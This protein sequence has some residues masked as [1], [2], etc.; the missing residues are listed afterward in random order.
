MNLPAKYHLR[1]IF[2]DLDGTL[3]DSAPDISSALELTFQALKIEPHSEQKVRQWVGNG[4]EKLLHRALTNSMDGTAEENIMNKARDVFFKEYKKNI[5]LYSKLYEGVEETLTKLSKQHFL[6]ACITNKNRA[7]TIPLLEK[8]KVKNYFNTIV[9]GDDVKHKKPAADHLL[10]GTRQLGVT[11]DQ[12]LMVGDSKTDVTAANNANMNIICV[13][14]GYNQGE[15]LNSLKIHSLISDFREI[16]P[17]L[18]D[19]NLN[20]AGSV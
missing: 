15:N 20:A 7:F 12:C 13:D 19:F 18:T 14:Y 16:Q 3:I 1:A 9:C 8:L 10:A 4:V 11:V 6:L 5:G 2:F 17:L